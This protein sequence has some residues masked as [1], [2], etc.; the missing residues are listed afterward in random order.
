VGD[1]NMDGRQDLLEKDGWWEN[2]GGSTEELWSFRPFQF[3]ATGGAQMFAVDFDGD[4]R[5]EILTSVAA[6]GFGL[7]YYKATSDKA[8]Q[9]DRFEIMTDKADSSPVGLAVS[10]LHA[11]AVADINGDQVPDIISGKRWWAHANKDPAAQQPATLFWLETKRQAGRASFVAHVIDNSSG[12]GTDITVGDV[13][14]D[15]LPDILSGTKRGTHLFLQRPGQMKPGQYLLPDL[16]KAD[17]FGHRPAFDLVATEGGWLP[18]VGQRAINLGFKAK[19]L[20]DWE[21]RGPAGKVALQSAAID[22]GSND[23]NLVGELVSRP[24][25]P[26]KP[27]LKFELSGSKQPE[28]LVEVVL[29]KNGQSIA[30]ASP[31]GDEQLKPQVF[32]LQ[33][34]QSELVRLRIVDHSN[35]GHLRCSGF[36]LMD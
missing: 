29:E 14:A 34:W 5:N 8:T 15:G 19:T 27:K 23:E 18:A 33:N 25:K 36:L 11:V 7:V 10:Q 3:S 32:D 20:E 22:T 35:K 21:A 28:L 30:S 13:N 31:E 9:F 4:G 6:H 16:A 1:V 24:F 17:R 2:P 12:V 26:S